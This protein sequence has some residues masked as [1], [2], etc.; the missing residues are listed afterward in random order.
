MNLRKAVLWL[1]CLSML[2][3][4]GGAYAG[5][6][7]FVEDPVE[8]EA[9]AS[10]DGLE[11][12]PEEEP[13]EEIGIQAGSRLIVGSQTAPNG[14]FS[15]DMWGNN[16]VDLD[17]RALLHGY[18]TVMLTKDQ[19]LI[20]DET[21]LKDV[22]LGRTDD[23]GSVYVLT[24]SDALKYN[25][26][27]PITARDYAFS[28][29][30]GGAPEVAA[31]GGTPQGRNHILGYTD[32][33]AG[34]AKAISGVR[35]VA[36]DTLVL[37][38]HPSYLPYFYGHA[39]ISIKPLPISEIA[40]GCEVQDD[41]DGIYIGT[42]A[43]AAAMD[44]S[45]LPYTP[46]IFSAD[47]LKETL[48]NE[49]TGYLSHPR[50]T[51]GPYSLV[52][53]DAAENTATFLIN[54]HYI[55]NFEGQKPHIETVEFR[56][57][58]P[59]TMVDDLLTGKVDLLN[60]MTDVSIMQQIMQGQ[61]PGRGIAQGSYLR[62]GFA[63]LAFACEEEPT[64]SVAVRRAIAMCIDKDA[65][66]NMSMTGSALKVN[67]YYGL[68]QWMATYTDD[69][70]PA[71]GTEPFDVAEPLAA[72]EL[73]LDVEAAGKLLDEDGWAYAEDGGAY[74]PGDGSFRHRKTD[75][76]YEPLALRLALTADNEAAQDV[77]TVMKAVCAELGIQLDIAELPF[78]QL[79][80]HYYRQEERTYN[81]FF[82]ASN[83]NYIFDPYYD[84]NTA[85]AY[86]GMLNT[87]GLRDEELM[88][89]AFDLRQT[90]VA[91][92]REYV[93]KWLLFQERFVQ[94]MPLI[95]LYSNVY[96]DFYV[97]TL[98]NYDM[99][100]HASWAYAVPYAYFGEASVEEADDLA[101]DDSEFLEII[102]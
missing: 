37:Y 83:F 38:I 91:Q 7:I 36:E 62:T 89:L 53:Y 87:S 42:S 25:D 22:Q 46:G 88:N 101:G 27:T 99:T 86:Q 90:P 82:L 15:T 58:Q 11:E 5:D 84:F 21:V 93:E 76:G 72:L 67:G 1:L 49:E 40:P 97:D 69:G 61:T 30:L 39:M 54:E 31:V 102:D 60:K 13:E 64:S 16:T 33:A 80:K 4:A 75:S 95:P 12:E 20:I 55:G 98:Q 79:L 17:I 47:M 57:V 2:M 81:M 24:F 35:L 85:D 48:L 50:K 8:V 66:I 44:A 43:D 100:R 9:L 94:E 26:G 70:D 41:G 92:M 14:M 32:Y 65:L 63:F 56:T 73:P 78:P 51:S 23:G 71:E 96:F 29:L 28:L 6:V 77:G 68:G 59:E 19:G 18:D 52:R 34:E 74:K 10:L 45:S 3:A